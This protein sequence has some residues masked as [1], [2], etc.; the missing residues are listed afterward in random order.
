MTRAAR[1]SVAG[2]TVSRRRGIPQTR[3]VESMWIT[4]E[5]LRIPMVRIVDDTVDYPWVT[6]NI[7]AL[8]GLYV[9]HSAV[10]KLG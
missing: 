5:L 9:V 4:A 6:L 7:V 8:T 10:Y 3:V 2:A 1:A